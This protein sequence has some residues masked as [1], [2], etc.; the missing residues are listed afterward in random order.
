L[1]EIEKDPPPNCGAGPVGEDIMHWQGAVMGP[2]GTPY[3]KGVFF[4]NIHFPP[5]YPFKAPKLQFTTK[6][7]HCK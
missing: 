1:T 4:L 5:E 2:E 7:Y 6:I 3:D